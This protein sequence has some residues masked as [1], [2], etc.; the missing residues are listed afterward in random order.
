MNCNCQKELEDKLTAN[1]AKKAPE[2]KN[3]SAKLQ[4]YGYGITN[5]GGVVSHGFMEVRATADYTSKR[6]ITRPRTFKKN[7]IFNFC[8]FFGNG[9]R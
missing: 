5:T 6:G 4:G 2:A 8:P 9:A 1:F 7:M 3:H